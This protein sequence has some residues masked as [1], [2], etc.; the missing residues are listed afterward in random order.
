MDLEYW[1]H[2]D[3]HPNYI[4]RLFSFMYEL[5]IEMLIRPNHA[6]RRARKRATR[7]HSSNTKALACPG[8]S[9]IDGA[10]WAEKQYVYTDSATL[11]RLQVFDSSICEPGSRIINLKRSQ[12]APE[13]TLFDYL[14][15]CS[16]T[17]GSCLLSKWLRFPLKD[18]EE[19]HR[20]QFAVEFLAKSANRGLHKLL[21]SCIKRVGNIQR[22]L[23]RMHTSAATPNE[24]KML[25]QTM[26]SLKAI[27]DVCRHHPEL[28]SPLNGPD[29]VSSPCQTLYSLLEKIIETIDMSST[30]SHKR[31][32]VKQGNHAWLDEWKQIYRC[33]P[34]IL[35]RLAEHELNRLRG[36]VDACGLIYFPLVGYLLQIPS[37]QAS[38]ELQELGL[39]YIFTNGELAYYRTATTKEL[40]KRYGD[41]MYAILDAE[42]SIMHELQ[43]EILKAAKPLLQLL[44]FVTELDCVCAL[45]TAAM[46]MN[47]TKPQV[48]SKGTMTIQ[49]GRHILYEALH[50]NYR[51]NSFTSPTEKGSVTLVTGPNASGK[52]M[53]IKQVGLIV[54]L[55]HVGS[56][57][58]ADYATIPLMDTILALMPADIER[59]AKTQEF[60]A[61]A[62]WLSAAL[63][64]A[65]ANSLLLLDEF[66]YFSD[67][68][69]K[70]L[71]SRA[72][73]LGG[74][75]VPV[76]RLFGVYESKKFASRD[77]DC[78]EY[79]LGKITTAA[80]GSPHKP[81][82]APGITDTN[83]A[84]EVASSAGIPREV[85][86]TASQVCNEFRNHQPLEF[87]RNKPSRYYREK[88]RHQTPQ[89]FERID[90]NGSERVYQ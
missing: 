34:D 15:T 16:S 51:T 14:N 27:M 82:V 62:S 17:L 75:K 63:R 90:R 59:E 58:P 85:I 68:V 38:E 50:T 30:Y 23:S 65:S 7:G 76:P 57:V 56:F 45:A 12:D 74:P 18:G 20:R 52:T 21:S 25:L 87:I 64:H 49:R 28:S 61:D 48:V 73:S 70:A 26:Q 24:W 1:I 33:L 84:L 46:R 67:Q 89:T 69:R 2:A 60:L 13:L 88:T 40:D 78:T 43:E 29:N 4:K 32:I 79:E 9:A 31:F 55:A 39:Q 77:S 3:D 19:L 41:V 22:V 37:S 71:A 6:A 36:N 47:G 72:I 83:Y 86:A 10:A 53:F 8:V 5:L 11:I 54:Y 66:P 80:T 35:S 81:E 42:T 44:D